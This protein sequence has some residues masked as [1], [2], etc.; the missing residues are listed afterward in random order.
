MV[1]KEA[2]KKTD[3]KGKETIDQKGKETI[4]QLVKEIANT[5]DWSVLVPDYDEDALMVHWSSKS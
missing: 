3:Q 4:D 5:K 2:T 1:K